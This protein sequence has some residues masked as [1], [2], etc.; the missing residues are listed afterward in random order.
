MTSLCKS[1]GS[2]QGDPP[3]ES[4]TLGIACAGPVAGTSGLDGTVLV[5]V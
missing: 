5:P 2:G 1:K 3:A 4:H